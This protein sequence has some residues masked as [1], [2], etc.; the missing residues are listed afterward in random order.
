[1]NKDIETVVDVER[2][3]DEPPNST[4]DTYRNSNSSLYGRVCR[5]LFS[6]EKN[7]CIGGH[8]CQKDVL[9]CFSR[10]NTTVVGTW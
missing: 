1:M 3:E 5:V 7:P 4:F 2:E 10:R 9:S 6:I 8:G